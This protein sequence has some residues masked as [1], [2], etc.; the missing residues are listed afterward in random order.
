MRTQDETPGGRDFTTEGRAV[1]FGFPS[2]T[3]E[4]RLRARSKAWRVGGAARALGIAVLVAPAV[5]VFPPHAPWL[6]GTL[7]VGGVLARRRWTEHFTVLEV[8]G[9]CPKCGAAL[10]VDSGRLRRPHPIACEGCHHESTLELADE[11]LQEHH[12]T[13]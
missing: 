10:E 5:A 12:Q 4:V 11:I 3:L 7:A 8:R 1:L 13:S 6:I 2:E 9:R